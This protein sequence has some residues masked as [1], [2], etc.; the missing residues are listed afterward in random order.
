[1]R[2]VCVCK[3]LEELRF[4]CFVVGNEKAIVTEWERE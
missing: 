4:S 3:D 1:M 2:R